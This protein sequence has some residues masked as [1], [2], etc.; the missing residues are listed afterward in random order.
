VTSVYVPAF[1]MGMEA[2]SLLFRYLQGTVEF[3]EEVLIDSTIIDRK[4]VIHRNNLTQ[5]EVI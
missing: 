4:S 3:N 1:K 2:A 5:G